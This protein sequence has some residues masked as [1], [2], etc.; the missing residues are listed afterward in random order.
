MINLTYIMSLGLVVSL[1]L[2]FIIVLINIFRV[3][4]INLK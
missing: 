1:P 3:I 2:T 4:K